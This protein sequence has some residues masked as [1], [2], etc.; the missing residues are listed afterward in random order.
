MKVSS[1]NRISE[2]LANTFLSTQCGARYF[3]TYECRLLFII[4]E[5]III[6]NYINSKAYTLLGIL[7]VRLISA[8][9]QTERW[10]SQNHTLY[11]MN[12][13]T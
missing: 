2:Q 4:I 8:T 13:D 5:R 7:T 1:V 11:F 9:V 12:L 10:G 6:Q 3:Q